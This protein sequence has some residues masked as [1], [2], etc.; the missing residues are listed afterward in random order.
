MH[1]PSSLF[2]AIL[3]CALALAATRGSAEPGEPRL[4]SVT[5]AGEVRAAPDRAI[6][7]LGIEAR[8]TTL[9]AAR[10]TANRVV[11]ALLKV[12]RDLKIPESS[13][14]ST[15][16]GVNPEYN[17]N[18]GRHQRQLVGYNVQRQLIVDLR[19]LER[20]GELIEK[21]VTAGANLVGDPILDSSERAD[22]ER[23]ALARAVDDARRNAAVLA[24]ALDAS[25]GPPRSVST[26][27]TGGRPMPLPMARV[28]A[29]KAMSAEAPETYQSG[30][31]TFTATV[32]A[33]FDLVP[34]A[35]PPR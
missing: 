8:E 9:E 18:D 33:T 26:T 5:G 20:L 6:V 27:A 17:W 25:V 31:L 29:A 19:D 15:R 23:Q 30:E 7:T 32:S 2:A 35:A 24:R 22:L 34:G 11:A 16:V 21:S 4:V 3:A 13:V 28:A 12:T 10:T 1:R 14:R